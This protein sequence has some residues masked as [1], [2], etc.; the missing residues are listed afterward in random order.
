M[1]W[2]VCKHVR[3]GMH[4][5]TRRR[6][7]AQRRPGQRPSHSD[8]VLPHEREQAAEPPV[9][10]VRRRQSSTSVHASCTSVTPENAMVGTAALTASASRG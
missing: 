10:T 5:M 4:G 1:C 2:P 6:L 7:D 9:V 8:L 3:L